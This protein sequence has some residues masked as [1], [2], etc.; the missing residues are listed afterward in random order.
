MV[1]VAVA[2]VAVVDG[3]DSP[4]DKSAP[5][6]LAMLAF[7]LQQSAWACPSIPHLPQRITVSSSPDA[8]SFV[9]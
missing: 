4:P 5:F 7:G 3:K 6:P 2:A 8:S 9:P 1:A